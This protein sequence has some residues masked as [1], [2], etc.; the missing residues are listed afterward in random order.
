MGLLER[1]ENTPRL[2]TLHPTLTEPNRSAA[3]EAARRDKRE[4]HALALRSGGAGHSRLAQAYRY[5]YPYPYPY[6]YP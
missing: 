5:P 4:Y 2:L 6:L 1:S 3:R